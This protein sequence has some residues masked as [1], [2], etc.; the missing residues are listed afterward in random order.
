MGLGGRGRGRR[1]TGGRELGPKT[2]NHL[3][4][5]WC[6]VGRTTHNIRYI[7][8]GAPATSRPN[9]SRRSRFEPELLLVGDSI[10]PRPT[11]L[12]SRDFK[13]PRPSSSPSTG[14]N[15]PSSSPS[16]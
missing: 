12:G 9:E 5:T 10:T 15:G 11:G 1:G 13:S 4:D 2:R 16:S 6:V 8:V 3:C 14:V 7:V